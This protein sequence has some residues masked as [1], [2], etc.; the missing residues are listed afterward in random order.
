MAVRD[1]RDYYYNLL[2]QYIEMKED[3]ADFEQA[4]KEG[5]ITEDKLGEVKNQVSIIQTNF[6]RIG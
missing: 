1:V 5:Y 2:N 4:F 6:E 3:L